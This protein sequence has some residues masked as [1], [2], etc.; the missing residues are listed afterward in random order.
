MAINRINNIGKSN[1]I[2]PDQTAIN[3]GINNSINALSNYIVVA[4]V[5]DIVLNENHEFFNRVGQYNGIGAIFYELVNQTG[6]STD[7]N[8]SFALPY[9]PQLKT[10]P[11]INE[12]VL[13]ISVPFSPLSEVKSST[14]YFY[15]NPVNIWNHPHHDAFPNP[16]P[17][18]NDLSPSQNSDYQIIS[19]GNYV[20]RVDEDNEYLPD[21]ELNSKRNPSQNTFVEKAD[22]HSLMPFMGDVLLEGRHGQ[23]IRFGSTAKQPSNTTP[24]TINNNWSSAGKNGDPI[25]IIRNGQP[26]NVDDK[27]W[28]PI[29]ENI[30]NDLSSIYLTSF[31]R[32]KDFKVAS[33]LYGSYVT[34]PIAPS[35]FTQPQIALNSNRVV[36]NAKTDSVLLSAQKSVGISTQGSANIDAELFYI[37]SNDIKLGSKNATEP[38]LK[39]DTTVELL[40]QLTKA[41]KD[42]ATILE[43][44]KNWPGGNLQTGY[45]AV[46]GNVLLVLNEINTQLNDNSLKS[47]TTKVQ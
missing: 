27:G 47:L 9:D 2:N 39:G 18:I 7:S 1:F 17:T 34:P 22:I 5:L 30:R 3:S 46:A 15:L 44:E 33:E 41:I 35:L 32:L 19:D 21:S 29:T 16:S 4:R 26:L 14:T 25:T 8:G 23:S 40:K 13:L 43:V 12:Y 20:R 24:L 45:N 11:L 31:Q 37:S 28:I 36:I 38:V 6:T 42:L 10:Y